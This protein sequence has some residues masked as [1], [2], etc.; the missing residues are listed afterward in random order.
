MNSHEC[1]SSN[2]TFPMHP[3]L[4]ETK[5]FDSGCSEPQHSISQVLAGAE[6]VED[7]L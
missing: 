3:N 1:V 2:H 7:V 6:H 5:S 4:Q